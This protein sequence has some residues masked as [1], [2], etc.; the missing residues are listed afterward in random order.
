MTRQETDESSTQAGAVRFFF[1]QVLLELTNA[2]HESPYLEFR[3]APAGFAAVPGLRAGAVTVR[4]SATACDASHISPPSL[5]ITNTDLS[6]GMAPRAD[7]VRGRF[8]D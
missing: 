1:A 3:Q 6:P 4:N 8:R 5:L 7:L 2:P